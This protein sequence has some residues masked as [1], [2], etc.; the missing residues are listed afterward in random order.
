MWDY[1][2]LEV[3]SQAA[4]KIEQVLDEFSAWEL[5]AVVQRR[6]GNL[7]CFLKRPKE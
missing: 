4:E 2:V 7:L 3:E 6:N 1:R 5:V